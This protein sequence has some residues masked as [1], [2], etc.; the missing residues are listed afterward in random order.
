MHEKGIGH[1]N[2]WYDRYHPKELHV[3]KLGTART[4]V[5]YTAYQRVVF[6][7]YLYLPY[8]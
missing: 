2:D 3:P 4:L 8:F 7:W 6:V 1:T 5:R